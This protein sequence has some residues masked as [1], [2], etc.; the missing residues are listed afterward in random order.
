LT[1]GEGAGAAPFRGWLVAARG[2]AHKARAEMQAAFKKAFMKL[3][4]TEVNRQN[5]IYIKYYLFARGV[6][7][8]FF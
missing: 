7:N 6:K 4:P 1:R 2:A 3:N 8:L 5:N